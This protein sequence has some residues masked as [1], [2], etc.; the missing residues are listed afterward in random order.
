MYH[1]SFPATL[2]LYL[3]VSHEVIGGLCHDLP[4]VMQWQW[5][6]N[7]LTPALHSHDLTL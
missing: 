2:L 4:E 3:L 6:L 5:G 7:R 1:Q